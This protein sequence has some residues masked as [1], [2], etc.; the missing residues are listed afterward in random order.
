L[1]RIMLASPVFFGISAILGSA[2]NARRHFLLPGLAPIVY[3]LS[4]TGGALFLSRYIGIEGVAWGVTAGSLAHL[5]VQ[6]PGLR[7]Q[8]MVYHL[9]FSISNPGVREVGRLMGPRVLGLAA[10]QVNFL[11]TTAL[12]SKLA[13]YSIPALNYAWM[14]M[15]L[16]LGLFAIAISSAVFPTLAEK[17]AQEM[18]ESMRQT[19]YV[20][21]KMILF[22]TIPASVGLIVLGR[23]LIGLL[24]QRGLFDELSA[25]ATY[26]ALV[27]YAIG[28]FGHGM[29]E[30]LTR[31]FYANHDT[32]TPVIIGIGAMALNIGLSLV[33]M[34][35]LGHGG[36]ALSVSLAAIME[37]ILLFR[38]I[39]RRFGQ[40]TSS[41][42]GPSL[43]RTCLAA[44]LMGAALLALRVWVPVPGTTIG[45]GI[46]LA[47]SIAIGAVL[48][49]IT[50]YLLGSQE[51]RLLR[52]GLISRG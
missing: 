7:R 44:A 36:L 6:V 34:G 23:P 40:Q 22:L 39:T 25:Q 52:A 27:F 5:L 45:L 42:L 38:A 47:A 48:F 30:I 13:S 1:T 32:R 19:I 41:A 15:L 9:I 18:G 31:A 3:N 17:A 33:L 29:V 24:F 49:L 35:P 20:T 46:Y 43:V 50:A 12:A 2:L 28:L 26:G 8:G 51:V 11:V 37:A 4:I 21:L 10:I 16:P 14:L